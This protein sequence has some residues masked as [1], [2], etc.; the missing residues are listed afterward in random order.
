MAKGYKATEYMYSSARLRALETAIAGRE[1]I[2]RFVDADGAQSI[3]SALSEYGFELVYNDLGELL[4]EETLMSALK[5][6]FSEVLGMECASAVRFLQY[7]YDC[8]NIK[9][10]IKCNARGISPDEMLLPFGTVSAEAAKNAFLNKDYSA[11]PSAMAKAIG[12]AEE[13]FAATA[14]PQKIDFTIDRACF[15]DMLASAEESGIELAKRL[16]VCKIDLLNIM[17]TLR[18]MRMGLKESATALADEV[19]IEG[20][21]LDKRQC[22]NAISDKEGFVQT[23]FGSRYYLL[24]PLVSDD[25]ALGDIEKRV[26]NIYL[27]AARQAKSVPF[28]AEVAIGYIFALEYE[29]KNIRIINFIINSI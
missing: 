7:Q 27:E 11:F 16:V 19:Y 13:A 17:Q 18:I 8:N 6:G 28:G 9:T 22:V 10:I 25:A 20:G 24:A 12:E 29:I 23:L 5:K 26:D 2:S 14:N 15:A 21:S 4:R 1:Q 3:I